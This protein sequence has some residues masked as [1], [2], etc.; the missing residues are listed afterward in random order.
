MQHLYNPYTGYNNVTLLQIFQYLFGTYG[1]ITELELIKNEQKM[2]IP[3][4]QDNP[5]ETIFYQI[6]E[7]I[8]FSQYGGAPFTNTQVLNAAFYIMA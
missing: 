4:N 5:I 8:E 3:W 1:N 2:K 6:K 7:C